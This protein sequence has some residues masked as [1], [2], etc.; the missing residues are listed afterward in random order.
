MFKQ[1]KLQEIERI[2]EFIKKQLS[3]AKKKMV[4]VGLSGGLDS[5]VTAALCAKALGNDKVYGLMLPYRSS[6]PASLADAIIVAQHLN[7]KF[8]KVDI[9]PMVDNYYKDEE[10][11]ADNLRKGNFMARIRMSVL[12]DHS[13]KYNA[14]V[15]G[16]GNRS[17][18]MIG[19][20]TQYG[21]NACAFEPIGHLYKTETFELAKYL[22]LPEEIISKKPTADLWEGQTDE[23]EM[24]ITYVN[25]DEILHLM[26]DKRVNDKKLISIFSEQMVNKVKQM[27]LKSEFKRIMPPVLNRLEEK[28]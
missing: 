10:Q 2:T 24:G 28:S 21:D 17:E 9:S 3:Y 13:A 18:L 1:D 5:S 27:I 23:E 11:E 7:V 26:L 4:V 25:L 22:K 20:S 8:R 6:D 14:L 15:A 16:T 19:Y 12:Y